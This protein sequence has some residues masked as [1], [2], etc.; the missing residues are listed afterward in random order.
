MD[1]ILTE[2]KKMEL[3][4]GVP[5]DV[6][7]QDLMPHR[8]LQEYKRGMFIMEPQQEINRFGIVLSGSVHIMHFFQEGSYSLTSV[9]TAGDMLGL[10]LVCTKTR[11]APYYAMAASTARVVFFPAIVLADP[12][13]WEG[14]WRVEV[15]R[16]WVVG[17]R[18]GI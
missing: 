1:E 9:L 8:Q 14:T 11:R 12:G 2:L 13:S 7:I 17:V 16:G 6:V 15:L 3:F 10:D 4:S 18:S 5:E